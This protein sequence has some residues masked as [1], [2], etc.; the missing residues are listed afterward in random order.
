[1]PWHA[2]HARI[3][4]H[5]QS[6]QGMKTLWQLFPKQPDAHAALRQRILSED[7]PFVYDCDTKHRPRR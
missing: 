7:G 2:K 3:Y 6:M 1:M 4:V 5:F